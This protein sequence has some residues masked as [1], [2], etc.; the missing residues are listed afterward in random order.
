MIGFNIVLGNDPRDVLT[1][2]SS[3][4]MFAAKSKKPK[5]Q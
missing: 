1:L 2:N 3:P 4:S 5:N